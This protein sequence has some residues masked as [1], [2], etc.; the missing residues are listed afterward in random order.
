M[1]ASL[2]EDEGE[3]TNTVARITVVRS[4]TGEVTELLRTQRKFF[5]LAV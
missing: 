1:V 5:E 3:N 2:A 4:A